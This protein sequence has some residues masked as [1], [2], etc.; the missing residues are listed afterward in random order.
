MAREATL[1]RAAPATAV[2]GVHAFIAGRHCSSNGH[3]VN[4]VWTEFHKGGRWRELD[5]GWLG[6]RMLGN[7]RLPVETDLAVHQATGATS[8]AGTYEV[9]HLVRSGATV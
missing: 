4:R 2:P 1:S 7:R 8:V 9:A 6:Q 5:R 3:V